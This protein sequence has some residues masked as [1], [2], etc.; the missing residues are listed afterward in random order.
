[1]RNHTSPPDLHEAFAAIANYFDVSLA[2]A[3]KARPFIGGNLK[4]APSASSIAAQAIAVRSSKLAAMI[5]I[6]RDNP[7]GASPRHQVEIGSLFA[8]DLD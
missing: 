2:A 7:S 1:M 4:H 6:L 5:W 3:L 8:I